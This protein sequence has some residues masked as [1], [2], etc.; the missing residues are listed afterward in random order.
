MD[1]LLIL[2]KIQE[3]YGFETDAKFAEFLDIPAQNLS[4]WKIRG[5]Y[6]IK[7]L[8]TKCTDINAEFILTGNGPISKSDIP[9]ILNEPSA[10][11][12]KEL[13]VAEL[14]EKVRFQEEQIEWYKNQLELKEKQ[15]AK[16]NLLDKKRIEEVF[17][18]LQKIEDELVKKSLQ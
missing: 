3:Y 7:T 15:L 5:S 4:K 6:N 13:T 1:K 17:K 16:K 2:N 10:D 8:C 9:T 14:Q 11:Y 12:K 18:S